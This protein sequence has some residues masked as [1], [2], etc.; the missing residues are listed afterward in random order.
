[1]P[2]G[3]GGG[4]RGRRDCLDDVLPVEF[5]VATFNIHGCKGRDGRR[6]AG[7]VAKCLEG[8]DIAGLNEVRGS[9]CSEPRDQVAQLADLCGAPGENCIFAPAET[10][11]FGTRQFGNGLIARSRLL[12]WQRIPLPR[13]YDRSCRNMLL[14]YIEGPSGMVTVLI[15]HVAR[16]NERE[17][18]IQL[19]AVLNLFASLEPPAILLADLNTAPGDPRMD[20]FLAESGAVDAIKEGGVAGNDRIDWILIRGLGCLGSERVDNDASDHPLFVARLSCPGS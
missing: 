18:E 10:Q 6:D 5:Q 4:G 3:P 1:M 7:R 8:L 17:R 14:A 12:A 13:Q 9:V 15:T 11:W 19:E 2:A 16:S 20:R